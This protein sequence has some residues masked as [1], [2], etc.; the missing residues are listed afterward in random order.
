MKIFSSEFAASPALRSMV[1]ST[2][3]TGHALVDLVLPPVCPLCGDIR[4]RRRAWC[5]RCHVGLQATRIFPTDSCARCAHPVAAD[6]VE[7]GL[8]TLAVGC[9]VCRARAGFP[10]GPTV[11]P[12]DPVASGEPARI[13]S[14]RTSIGP[15]GFPVDQTIALFRYQGLARDAVVA[16]KYLTRQP[17]SMTLGRGLASAIGDASAP[18][19]PL[20][21]SRP[22]DVVTW[23]P[24]HWTRRWARGGN[25]VEVIAAQAA[26][27]LAIP[28]V[29]LLKT[30][31]QIK[32]Q[33]WLSDP[34]RQKNV[35]GAFT[36]RKSYALGSTGKMVKKWVDNQHVLVID[37]VLTTGATT[38]E[39]ARVLKF[40]GAARVSVAVVARAVR[41]H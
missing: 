32:K 17:L 1:P 14:H 7:A 10:N 8:A 21:R 16:S 6:M 29:G 19:Q 34:E 35:S 27:K 38:G 23:V 25:S 37:D 26:R 5:R 20:A 13:P 15:T 22:V 2:R 31:R 3:Q 41:D 4:D 39:I 9:V 11:A 40:V 33:A 30:T 12:G 36:V 28:A 24:S 18:G